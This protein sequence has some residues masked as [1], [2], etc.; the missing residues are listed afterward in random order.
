MIAFLFAACVSDAPFADTDPATEPRTDPV[1]EPRTEAVTK[2]PETEPPETGPVEPYGD[3]DIVLGEP[4]VVF[5]GRE[6]DQGW[7]KHQFPNLSVC[8]DGS[9]RIA[10]MYGEDKVGAVGNRRYIKM[11][12]DGGVRWF[13]G[14][15]GSVGVKEVNPLPTGK[16]FHGFKSYGTVRDVDYTGYEPLATWGAGGQSA[17]YYGPDLLGCDSAAEKHVFTTEVVLYDAETG[18]SETVPATVNWPHY[19]VAVYYGNVTYTVSGWFGLSGSNWVTAEDAIYTCIYARGLN[20]DAKTK[21]DALLEN[22]TTH[23]VY[24]FKSVDGINWDYLSQITA[25]DL[26]G[27]TDGPCEPKMIRMRDGSFV[28]LFRTGSDDP[29]YYTRSED[30]CKTWSKPVPFHEYGVLP[31]LLTLDCGVTLSTFGRPDLVMRYSF[32]PAGVEWEPA[33][34]IPLTLNGREHMW[35]NSCCYTNLLPLSD[36][37]ALFI[38]SDFKY[39]NENGVGVRTI[40]T[41]E[42]TVVEK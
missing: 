22:Y 4:V 32:D 2:A 24:V 35:G 3:F 16:Y 36:T 39:P 21:E 25:D 29:M 33:Q 8:A 27:G 14:D 13:F 18:K 37:K 7:G 30:M 26:T 23:S 40:L 12:L 9:L 10:W 41:R 17:V 28:M 20:S 5:Q 15:T 11:S 42:I 31:Q 6:N 34:Q 1:T 38:Y 19:P